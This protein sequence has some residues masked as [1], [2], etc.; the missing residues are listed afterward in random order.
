MEEEISLKE[1]IQTLWKGRYLVIGIAIAAMIISG[2]LSFFVISPTY[3]ASASLMASPINTNVNQNQQNA[4]NISELLDALTTTPQMNVESYKTMIKSPEVI[5]SVIKELNL[6]PKRYTL[7]SLTDSITLETVQNTNL[8]LIKV[9]DKS[10]QMAADIANSLSKNFVS[11]VN[12]KVSEQASKT[13]QVLKQQ[14]DVEAQRLD[15]AMTKLKEFLSQPRSV[16]ELQSEVT[17]KITQLTD[18][19][20]RLSEAQIEEKGLVASLQSARE[21]L[22]DTPQTIKTNQAIDGGGDGSLIN[23][24]GLTIN[25]EVANPAYSNLLDQ[26]NQLEVQLS[27]VRAQKAA[28][29]ESIDSA[30]KE[31]NQLQL[32]LAEKQYQYD[33]INNDVTMAKNSYE[34]LQQKYQETNIASSS[35]IGEASIIQVSSAI[36]PEEPVSPRKLLNIAIAAVLGLMI[37][38]FAVFF[39]AYWNSE[40]DAEG[41]K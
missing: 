40:P 24:N 36:P 26:I 3:E 23:L 29:Q 10:P 34:A 21:Q 33:K 41:V 13:A 38:V 2:V 5:N 11:F 18:Y 39:I 28:L 6:D 8:I 25:G 17:A 37:G 9:K 7:Q 16:D 19:K 15:E 27:Q 22:K 30:Q 32:E 1:L 35:Q 20:G 4:N 12:Q 31:L 14:E